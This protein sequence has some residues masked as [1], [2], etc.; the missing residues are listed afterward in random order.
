MASPPEVS[1]FPLN[2]MKIAF[3][4]SKYRQ[5]KVLSVPMPVGSD[6]ELLKLVFHVI[7]PQ[8]S[9]VRGADHSES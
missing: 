9:N 2:R 7:E 8:G 5:R 1:A 6:R 3:H 4:P